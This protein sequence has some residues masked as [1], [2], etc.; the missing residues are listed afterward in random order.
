MMYIFLF[1]LYKIGNQQKK[2]NLV[3]KKQT[4]PD[5]YYLNTPTNAQNPQLRITTYVRN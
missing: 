2:M 1:Q 4:F 3:P 5:N